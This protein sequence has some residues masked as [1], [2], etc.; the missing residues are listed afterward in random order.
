MRKLLIIYNTTEISRPANYPWYA[1]CL[2]AL[3]NQ[4]MKAKYGDDYQIAVSG[5]CLSDA[6]QQ[7]LEM[8][9]GTQVSLNYTEE[10]VP[11]SISF[12]DTVEQCVKHFGPFE[13]YLYLD[14]GVTFWDPS[15]RNDAVERLYDVHKSYPNCM[16]A[17]YPSN[18]D[19]GSYWGVAYRPNDDHILPLG[20]AT[21]LH[22]QI[23]SEEWRQAYGKILP[24]IFANDTMESTFSYMAAA[25][26]KQYMVTTQISVLHLHSLDGASCGQRNTTN[27]NYTAA[28]E[29]MPNILLYK[30]KRN[31]DARHQEGYEFGFG[32]EGCKNFWPHDP[33]KFDGNGMA[34]DDR[35]APW[36][37]NNLFLT[38][39]EFDYES[40]VRIF[41]PAQ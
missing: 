3:I 23:W 29:H 28:S 13:S 22:C 14:S 6:T 2:Q 40:L 39:E 33:A 35:L 36:I 32:Y 38:K 1:N 19:G 10:P 27:P 26:R 31:M 30:T 20:R 18:D 25:L 7:T 9:F 11:L 5:C 16:T 37:R 17:A 41:R 34:I 21:N 8:H 24:D 4:T 15:Q 12:N